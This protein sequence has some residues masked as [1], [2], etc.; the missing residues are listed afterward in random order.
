M[1]DLTDEVQAWLRTQLDS[2]VDGLIDV[3]A[4]DG[5]FIEVKAAW[6]LPSQILV[7]SAREQGDPVAFRW[8]I[9]GEVPLDHIA[10]DAAASPRE[11]I[12]YFAMK[13]QL[14]SEKL[15]P[16]AAKNLIDHA[17]ALYTLADDD[18]YWQ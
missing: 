8:F 16:N 9:C 2:A 6:I 12:R 7:G 17:E 14:D 11:A 10:A 13:W 5:A 3:S 1:S 18:R 15:D 4:F